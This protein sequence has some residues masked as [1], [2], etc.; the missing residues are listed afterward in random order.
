MGTFVL[1]LLVVHIQR[2]DRAGCNADNPPT[3]Q[4][5][6]RLSRLDVHV[7]YNKRLLYTLSKR[8][9]ISLLRPNSYG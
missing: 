2:R 3:L 6:R 1:D 9:N 8:Y 4:P 5:L 7:L